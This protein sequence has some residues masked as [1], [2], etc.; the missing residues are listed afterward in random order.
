MAFSVTL[1]LLDNDGYEIGMIEMITHCDE[2]DDIAAEAINFLEQEIEIE[3]FDVYYIF[4]SSIA[5]RKLI[6][7]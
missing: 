6:I 2:I 5:G 4:I 7:Y 3:L 1:H